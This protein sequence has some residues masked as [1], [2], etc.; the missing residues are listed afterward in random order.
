MARRKAEI[1]A[2]KTQNTMRLSSLR[3]WIGLSRLIRGKNYDGLLQPPTNESNFSAVY[4][5]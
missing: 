5:T 3:I 4:E 1:E 2:K